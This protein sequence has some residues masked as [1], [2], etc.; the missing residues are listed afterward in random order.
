MDAIRREVSNF[1][2][3]SVSSKELAK[4]A[5]VSVFLVVTM[6]SALGDLQKLTAWKVEPFKGNAC[7]NLCFGAFSVGVLALVSL[8]FHPVKI[9]LKNHH[10][11]LQ[12]RPLAKTCLTTLA[13][14][15]ITALS[16]KGLQKYTKKKI[17]P[18]KGHPTA[19]AF[20]GAL[21]V[22]Y[23]AGSMFAFKPI[24]RLLPEDMF[25]GLQGLS[26]AFLNR[27]FESLSGAEIAEIRAQLFE[28]ACQI[29]RSQEN[30]T[31]KLDLIL[32][33]V[34]ERSPPSL[35][36][37]IEELIDSEMF[38]QE[39]PAHDV[40]RDQVL[41]R[42][43]QKMATHDL[44]KA[45]QIANRINNLTHKAAAIDCCVTAIIENL[46]LE[47][48]RRLG[49]VIRKNPNLDFSPKTWA[50]VV[51]YEAQEN[52]EG[53]LQTAMSARYPRAK[54]YALIEYAKV[55]PEYSLDAIDISAVPP[56]LR[57]EILMELVKVAATRDVSQ[58]I[59]RVSILGNDLRQQDK[60][61]WEAEAYIEIAKVDSEQGTPLALEKAEEVENLRERADV[62]VNIA[63]VDPEESLRR[64]KPLV[65]QIEH[66]DE[67][68]VII[69]K[70]IQIEARLRIY[71]AIKTMLAFSHLVGER[72]PV[73]NESVNSILI[74][75]AKKAPRDARENVFLIR[76][77]VR[78][79]KLLSMLIGPPIGMNVKSSARK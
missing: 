53:A 13:L 20:F 57:T 64:L 15:T 54:A 67:R 51:K 26:E 49:E 58:A 39:Y 60:A 59:E 11:Q 70:I 75:L 31:T 1:Q 42:F 29:A 50:T 36:Q 48:A 44:K 79:V 9:T 55:D 71:D 56:A 30:F 34:D 37:E 23:L 7:P 22:S 47:R 16:L 12:R 76:D 45:Q 24:S 78:K 41:S 28:D 61:K 65:S 8:A 17:V 6:K 66:V 2:V 4:A 18:L 62:F 38:E 43:S 46:S 5:I 33:I 19:N 32:E 52:R 27:N 35:M 21:S 25:E 14:M 3:E 63:A 69:C 77:P 73:I 74:A 68:S 40:R 72:P 10:Y